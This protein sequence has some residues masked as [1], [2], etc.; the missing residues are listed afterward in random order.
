MISKDTLSL[1]GLGIVVILVI[2]ALLFFEY[3]D[4]VDCDGR[5]GQV[6]YNPGELDGCLYKQK[7]TNWN[8]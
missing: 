8:G 6:I 4:G 3:Y 2:S 5:G 1:V 7:G